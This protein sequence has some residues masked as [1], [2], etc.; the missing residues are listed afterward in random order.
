M[1]N[2]FSIL[3]CCSVPFIS[4]SDEAM[5]N[6]SSTKKI[7]ERPN[8]NKLF[9]NKSHIKQ[10]NKK[11]DNPFENNKETTASNE[12]ISPR[13]INE[14][15][16]DKN[17]NISN[18]SKN[19]NKLFSSFIS[20]SNFPNQISPP[21]E[22]EDSG[23][24][25]LCSGELFFGKEIIIT[26]KGMIDS[27]RNKKDSQTFF[28]LKNTTDYRGIYYN[29]FVINFRNDDE[30]ID[31]TDSSTGRVFTIAFQKKTKDFNLYMISD[32]IIIYY[33]INDFVYFNN[34]SDY[35]LLLGNIF[36]SIITKKNN[37]NLKEITIEIEEEDNRNNNYSFTE[38]DTPITIGRGN[39]KINI[40]KPSIS[41]NHGVI[42]FSKEC[43]MFY[44]KD[45][46]STN[47]SILLMKE[48]DSLKIKGE[49]NFK[50]ENIPFKI[51]ELP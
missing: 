46:G 6:H 4:E 17:S 51:M 21:I 26:N 35:Y 23:P 24:K 25:L 15:K 11:K 36:I 48:D 50:L 8:V 29:D 5:I 34:E 20:F 38:N 13:F 2:I 42:E 39:C 9:E 3:N 44:F 47:G 43:N 14:G 19:K 40:Q 16:D 22:K 10:L 1:N 7:K 12:I 18:T 37:N 27:V 31:K 28:G 30:N 49:M 41:K 33:E 32:S 45:C